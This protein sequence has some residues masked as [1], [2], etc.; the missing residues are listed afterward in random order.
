[1]INPDIKNRILRKLA[2]AEAEH[3]VKIVLAVESGSRA[4]GFDSPNSDYDTRFIYVHKPDWYLC[5]GLEEQ[6]DV[7]EYPIVDELDINGWDL[8]KALR[9]FWKSNPGFIEWI[10]SPIIYRQ[11]TSFK[12][13]V[14]RLLPEVY[15]IESGIYH[16][17]SMAKTNFKSHL[18]EELVPLKKYFYVLRALLSVRWLEAYRMPAP[19]EFNKLLHLVADNMPLTVAINQLL[20]QKRQSDEVGLS[21]PIP[22]IH[23]F[24]QAEFERLEAISPAAVARNN[25]EPQLSHLFRA[26]L[27]EA[28]A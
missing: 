15:S 27:S 24:I 26:V 28:W 22:A 17:R 21:A 13:S 12:P 6:R 10:Q 25:V 9:L 7:I 18:N 4:W 8:R 16:Y 3:D 14:F 20:E 19:I 1:M 23:E 5:V 2:A 11:H